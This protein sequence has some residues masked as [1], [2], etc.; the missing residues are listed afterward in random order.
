[1][2]RWIKTHPIS[3]L[4][5]LALLWIT[6]MITDSLHTYGPSFM[7]DFTSNW[8]A[9]FMGVVIGVPL[10]MW[11]NTHQEKV[12]ESERKKKIL[13]LLY[14]ELKFNLAELRAWYSDQGQIISTSG[15]FLAFLKDELWNAF[16]DGGEIQWIK[17]LSLLDRLSNAYFRVNTI[18]RITEWVVTIG[19]ASK[20]INNESNWFEYLLSNIEDTID[21]IQEA[22]KLIENTVDITEK[23]EL[24]PTFQHG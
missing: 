19:P 3:T 22:L 7:Q 18:R 12:I 14:T 6:F 9:T 20:A 10:A 21:N 1:M 13:T 2:L 16:S 4:L 8:L 23:A 17:D 15:Y 5:I 11:A 24:T